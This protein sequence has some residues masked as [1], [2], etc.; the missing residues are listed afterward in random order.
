MQATTLALNTA[1]TSEALNAWATRAAYEVMVEETKRRSDFGTWLLYL[2]GGL[3]LIGTGYVI[4][5]WARRAARA[6]TPIQAEV[7]FGASTVVD[8]EPVSLPLLPSGPM[9]APPVRKIDDLRMA[10]A[11]QRWWDSQGTEGHDEHTSDY[12]H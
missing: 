12:T 4:L 2:A 6:P 8:V 5:A 1:A 9:H 11:M 10:Q 7:I 3:A